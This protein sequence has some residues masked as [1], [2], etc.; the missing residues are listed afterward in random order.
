[1]ATVAFLTVGV[2]LLLAGTVI[3]H[4]AAHAIAVVAAAEA[5][6]FALVTLGIGGATLS[7]RSLLTH[8]GPAILTAIP[9]LAWWGVL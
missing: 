4:D 3:D 2:A 6:A 5:T 8:P 9:A 7:P 1:V